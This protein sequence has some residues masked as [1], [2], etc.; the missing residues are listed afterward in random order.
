MK[1]SK[2]NLKEMIMLVIMVITVSAIIMLLS[3]A[4]DKVSAASLP[5][6]ESV[7]EMYRNNPYLRFYEGDEGIAWT[8][9]H[10]DGYSI[11]ANGVY[12]YGG[13]ISLYK[14]PDGTEVI[15][16]GVVSRRELAGPLPAGH[17]Y[18]AKPLNNTVIPVGRWVVSQSEARCIHGPFSACRDYEYYGINGLSNVKC[19]GKYDSGWIAYCADCGEQITGLVYTNDDCIRR[20]GYVFAGDDEFIKKYP[21]E[22]LFVC[23]ICG[24]NLENDL[25]MVSHDCKCFISAN[26]YRI[27]YDGN[28]ATRG[29]MEESVCYYG[30][31]SEYEGKNVTGATALRE[32]LYVKP[33]YLFIGWS[34]SPEGQVLFENGCS[35]ASI[36]NYFTYLSDAGDESNDR[37]IK[38]YAVWRRSDCTLAVSGGEFEDNNGFYNG[39][40]SGSYE[41]GKNYFVKGCMYETDI[42]PELLTAPFGYRIDLVVPGGIQMQSIYAS[43]HLT[44]WEFDSDD[45]GALA[46]S[47]TEGDMHYSGRLS[48]SIANAESDGSFTYIH[49]SPVN[50]NIDRARAVW[51]S[52]SVI[53]P[54]AV[55]PGKI[56]D[57]WYTDPNLKPDTYVGKGGDIFIPASDTVLYAGFTGLDLFASPDYMGNGNF[58][59]LRYSGLT[60]LLIGR[61]TEYDIYKYYIS[62]EYPACNWVEAATDDKGGYGGSSVRTFSGGG[63]YFEYTAPVSGIYT[64]ELWGAAG[65]SYDKYKGENGEYSYCRIYLKKGDK[66]G[67]YTGS[68]GTVTTGSSGTNCYGGE[69]SYISVNGNIIMSSSGGKGASFILN[70]RK[71]YNYT[72][73]VQRFTAEAEGDYTLQVWGA[74]GGATSDGRDEAGKGGYAT[75]RVH[76]NQGSVLYICVGGRNGYNGGGAGGYDA[77]WTRG[78]SGGGATHIASVSGVLRDLSAY[79]NNIYLVAGGGGGAGGSQAS[80]GYGGGNIGGEGYS[81]WPDG[82]CTA[83]GGTDTA[84][85]W[86]GS[87]GMTIGGF[88]YGGAGISYYPD[89]DIS[90]MVNNGGGGGGWYGGA[91]GDA[92]QKSYGCGG[93]GGS[94]Y[95]G[96]VTGGSMSSGVRSGNGSAV[97]TCSVSIVGSGARGRATS[98]TPGT[99]LY[100]GYRVTSHS[101]CVYPAADPS[102][103]GFCTITEPAEVF[104]NSSAC[105]ILSPDLDSPNPVSGVDLHYDA[106]SGIL[107][108]SW[109]MPDDNGTDYYYMA[110]A[111]RSSDVF[112]GVT[113]KYASTSVETLNIK[114]G[115]YKYI[116]VMDSSPTRDASYVRNYG[117]GILT[118]WAMVSGTYPGALFS[119]WYAQAPAYAVRTKIEY[120]PNGNDRYI[121][122]IAA[123][124]AGN[125]SQV[126]NASIDGEGAHVPYPVVTENMSVVSAPNVYAD[127]ERTDTYY[128][129]ADGSTGFS[130]RYSAYIKGYA[131]STYQVDTARIHLS[132]SEYAEISFDRNPNVSADADALVTGSSLFGPFPM[133]LSEVTGAARTN[134]SSTLS[135]T[136]TFTTLS[137]E[138]MYIYPSAHA[139]LESGT[140]IVSSDP[141][142][143]RGHGLTIIG[144]SQ[145]PRCAV[146]VNGSDYE[147]LTIVNISN[148]SASHVVDRRYEDVNIDLYVTDSGSGLKDNFNVR[149]I[150]LD[151]GL[152]G[153]YTST[154]EHLYLQL[155]QDPDSEEPYFD[156]MLF[157]GRIVIRVSAEDNVGNKETRES[158]GLTEL[159]VSGEIVRTLDAVTGPLTDE[160]GRLYIKKGESGYVISRVWG[161]PD[162][163]LVS[164][165][166]DSLA[167]YD[168]LY[169][170]GSE[171]PDS[172]SGFE[173]RVVYT[174]SPDYLF[175]NNT[176]FTV[177]LDYEGSSI[178]VIITG[179]K[180]DAEI[181][182]ETECE[183]ISSGSVLDELMT[184]LR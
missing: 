180:G 31:A 85:G 135:F 114:T 9:I 182:W 160:E 104:Y 183:V 163:V 181:T 86:S 102:K 138:E 62:S 79:K 26:R 53:L 145:A 168:V 32:N 146:S 120:V 109:D 12:T 115:V 89:E 17:H 132:G 67:I 98:F 105:K 129:R 137:E 80:S 131:R 57:G 156:N 64:F 76:L 173:G 125:I 39:V 108:I 30:N 165:E 44:G 161:Y 16:D 119:E 33:G 59:N 134:C 19:H 106:S 58:G 112:K 175:E 61:A 144:D 121:H 155:K 124:R 78:G 174:G 11:N 154:G 148:V 111:Y 73:S 3:Y 47:Y 127:P 42:D 43:S 15:P 162:A 50:N 35:T 36:E 71:E 46:F 93:G 54:E 38:L 6:A 92:K 150:N 172:L 29:S 4:G 126:L 100:S 117:T 77:W 158:A 82:E 171:I 130:I 170:T 91:G 167:E 149:V 178:R 142:D 66:V 52:T 139:C 23:P 10:P 68:A 128:V 176:D 18:Y 7:L 107:G 14:A 72:G 27:I 56:F 87:G 51:K 74:E 179:F 41:A 97:I 151:N 159:D 118:S 63:K 94:G 123:D 147:E 5:S 99:V 133:Q 55:F 166:G 143:D 169:V 21:A 110:R 20:I 37:E 141:A 83:G 184:V 34:D 24:D 13:G 136:G 45:A 88:G 84:P 122:I 116:Y 69:G 75:G 8:T 152:E 22:Y 70:V 177:P 113:D 40:T 49:S 164:F 96:G 101:Q 1:R 90:A 95:I 81:P 60:D 153:E 28:G 25:H 157:N 2:E 103:A 140:E 65:A 48:G